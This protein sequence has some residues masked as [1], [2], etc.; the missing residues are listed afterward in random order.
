MDE[1]KECPIIIANNGA[2]VLHC[3]YL[4]L[5]LLALLMQLLED[6]LISLIA[7]FIN[8]STSVQYTIVFFVNL[9]ILIILGSLVRSRRRMNPATT[10]FATP[11]S[12][13]NEAE[14]LQAGVVPP[15]L[16]AE[17][18]ETV[19]F[20][21]PLAKHS[22][23]L[24]SKIHL[25]P[26]WRTR[27]FVLNSSHLMYY[28]NQ[29]AFERNKKPQH[30]F[31]IDQLISAGEPPHNLNNSTNNGENTLWTLTWSGKELLLKS[32]S[33]KNKIMWMQA[34]NNAVS[35]RKHKNTPNVA[36]KPLQV[37][38][39][40][41][42]N[43]EI[44]ETAG[45][46]GE[47]AEK[48]THMSTQDKL[49]EQPGLTNESIQAET[50]DITE[51]V[52]DNLNSEK[53]GGNKENLSAAQLPVE[54]NNAPDLPTNLPEELRK[55]D[56]NDAESST[57]SSLSTTELENNT[58]SGGTSQ[59]YN[60][61]VTGAH[62]GSTGSESA[63]SI[64]E[65]A[66]TSRAVKSLY[67]LKPKSYAC[68]LFRANCINL[69]GRLYINDDGVSFYSHVFD[70][71]TQIN[72]LFSE[73]TDLRLN[74]YANLHNSIEIFSENKL[75]SEGKTSTSHVF[76]NFTGFSLR[77]L[78]KLLQR[79]S[80]QRFSLVSEEKPG[81][82]SPEKGKFEDHN[83]ETDAERSTSG[84]NNNVSAPGS[85]NLEPSVGNIVSKAV[86]KESTAELAD[87]GE[88][89]PVSPSEKNTLE[90]PLQTIIKASFPH[91]TLKTLMELFFSPETSRNS[92]VSLPEIY[93]QYYHHSIY[94]L[95]KG[96]NSE[97]SSE[98][99]LGG[100]NSLDFFNSA[101]N[102]AE[103]A[104]QYTENHENSS[105]SPMLR[106]FRAL[107]STAASIFPNSNVVSR[108][109]SV[110]R[111]LSDSDSQR[112]I[113]VESI[114]TLPDIQFGDC[115]IVFTEI[116]ASAEGNS[117]S[118]LLIQSSVRFIKMPSKLKSIQRQ[119]TSK[120]YAELRKF[121]QFWQ[122]TVETSVKL[123]KFSL[124]S[125]F[126]KHL[127]HTTANVNYPEGLTEENLRVFSA[128]TGDIQAQNSVFLGNVT[129]SGEIEQ[130]TQRNTEEESTLLPAKLVQPANEQF[131]KPVSEMMTEFDKISEVD[132]HPSYPQPHKEEFYGLSKR[133]SSA[134]LI[135]ERLEDFLNDK[136]FQE[137][138]PPAVEMVDYAKEGSS[139][140]AE[141]DKKLYIPPKDL[142]LARELSNHYRAD[143]ISL[144]DRLCWAL[145]CGFCVSQDALE[146]F[147]K[148]KEFEKQRKEKESWSEYQKQEAAR[149]QEAARRD[150]MSI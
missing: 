119:F 85:Y 38:L 67:K 98:F 74:N 124:N 37:A 110:Q 143:S 69:M 17:I 1:C 20:A 24:V 139:S 32:P 58:N 138:A 40:L 2:P 141:K 22:N 137:C 149:T 112:E 33:L 115:F 125:S 65:L 140:G 62:S 100:W 3:L 109:L 49:V 19:M 8:L 133:E 44:V 51:K 64:L 104:P 134:P 79:H 23:S 130:I 9:A 45:N 136:P 31:P 4:N 52:V 84:A 66:S 21:G 34:I 120:I 89:I 97:E 113:V 77:E 39:N 80:L 126:P 29:R 18:K 30:D 135:S 121:W 27:Y 60:Y 91:F 26:S 101:E 55:I 42:I 118:S 94:E 71:E 128:E 5:F 28:K 68:C 56:Y 147:K 73:I 145:G 48:P 106:D 53:L 88:E 93:R 114:E 72:L 59:N 41:N 82:I 13:T 10:T 11:Q 70:L 150:S 78:H 54:H 148:Q 142:P 7:H 87:L 102:S 103:I 83:A 16:P 12:H 99:A 111:R 123:E 116:L 81:E 47:I 46:S 144:G 86:I 131:S 63:V 76:S 127:K 117:A 75:E 57:V 122:K 108:L 14:K 92:E 90:T 25:T 15:H 6:Y 50:T 61:A 35:N 36:E 132:H 43:K 107:F 105:N 95:K 96:D 129:H 146:E